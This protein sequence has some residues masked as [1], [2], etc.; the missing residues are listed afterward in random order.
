MNKVKLKS[1]YEWNPGYDPYKAQDATSN[2]RSVIES[3]ENCGCISCQEIY[4][5]SEIKKWWS[6]GN[7]ACC[8][9]CGLTSVVIGS[10]SGLPIDKYY[11]GMAG[12][13]L[14]D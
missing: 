4:P 7:D 13:H 10:A 2:H 6:D 9:Y 1:G 8:P 5:P 11:L 3:S 14:V 12:G